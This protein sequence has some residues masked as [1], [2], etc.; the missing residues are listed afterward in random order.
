VAVVDA[1]VWGFSIPAMLGIDRRR[2]CSTTP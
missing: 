1:D 2:R